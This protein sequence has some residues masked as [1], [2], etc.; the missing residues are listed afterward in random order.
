MTR[1]EQVAKI[2]SM[3]SKIQ[4]KTK[5]YCIS[6]LEEDHIVEKVACSLHK[7]RFE[8]KWCNRCNSFTTHYVNG[9]CCKCQSRESG[10]GN[11]VIHQK[12]IDNQIKNGTFNMLQHEVQANKTSNKNLEAKIEDH[13]CDKCKRITKHRVINE[14]K[15]C[16]NCM[17]RNNGFHIKFCLKCNKETTHNGIKCIICHPES[18]SVNIS[19][20]KKCNAST[21]HNGNFCT[22]CHP[23][24]KSAAQQPNFITKNNVRFYKGIE[25]NEFATKILSGELNSDN[26]PGINIRFGRVYYKTK[27]II[28]GDIRLL[29][30]SNFIEENNILYYLNKSSNDYI[31][32][33]DYKNQFKTFN[34]DWQLPEGFQ[35]IPTFR[36][37][38]SDSW[39]GAKAAFEQF[40]VDLN[41]GW[42]VYIKFYISANNQILP[43]VVG[44]SGS[45]LVNVSGSD[46]SFSTNPDD[47]PARRFLVEEKLNWCQTQIAILKCNNENEAYEKE[48][49]FLIKYNLYDS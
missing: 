23:E 26:F 5:T 31:P 27:D 16:Y 44:K 40:L 12:T 25:V 11:P 39:N 35:L 41:I 3:I 36:T 42:F 17:T 45:L 22:I 19:F 18:R 20:C 1:R 24:S 10:L 38:D 21:L 28:T 29:K 4:D 9:R 8:L 46:L 7:S 32:W 33:T 13:F 2:N 49:E 47:G 15:Y 30:N 14:T 37:Q 43:L 34:I 48:K 6:C